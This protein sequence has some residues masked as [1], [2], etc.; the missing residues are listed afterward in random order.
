M[1]KF[2][3]LVLLLTAFVSVMPSGVRAEQYTIDTKKAHAFIQFK[4]SHLGYSW[5]LGRF[6][7]FEGTFSF[8]EA[9]PEAS[10]VKV[11]VDVASVD[12]NHAERDKHLRSKDFF[13]VK[14]YPEATF[15][16]RSFK[17]T[18]KGA[19]VMKGDF[20]LHGVTKEI[21]IE[22]KEVG[23]GKDPW[24][25]FRRGFEGT[26]TLALKDYNITK[27]LGPASATVDLYLSIEGI[28][29]K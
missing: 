3:I 9:R 22:V 29:N 23:A 4:I 12:T 7:D 26:T 10:K 19:A 20:T 2:L 13:E 18:G 24:G 28:R 8:N 11:S 1:K 15:I 21:E 25:G 16:S 5:L 17:V 6:N 27:N 14:K